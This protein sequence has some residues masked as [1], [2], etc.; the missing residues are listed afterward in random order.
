MWFIETASGLG[1]NIV[2]CA[3]EADVQIGSIV[4]TDEDIVVSGDSDL[5]FYQ[6]CSQ[7]IRPLAGNQITL[8]L[9]SLKCKELSLSLSV[10]QNFER[11]LSCIT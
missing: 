6:N 10:S 3:G 4:M 11:F 8:F 7:V 5:L 2:A 1:W 9:L